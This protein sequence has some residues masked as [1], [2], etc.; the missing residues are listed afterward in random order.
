MIYL[1]TIVRRNILNQL[2]S[3][4]KIL[5]SIISQINQIFYNSIDFG[6]IKNLTT[7]IENFIHNIEV[8]TLQMKKIILSIQALM[9]SSILLLPMSTLEAGGCSSN[10]NKKYESKC[11][12]KDNNCS[13][14]NSN[15]S[16][17][18]VDV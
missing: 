6:E 4:S 18:K 11:L 2:K 1:I 13:K 16:Q 12:G 7:V 8:K 14:I 17:N 5:K 3:V 10:Q 15:K 9:F